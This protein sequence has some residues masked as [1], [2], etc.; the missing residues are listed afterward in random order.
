[1]LGCAET[2]QKIMVFM[3][4]NLFQFVHDFGV[5]K[6]ALGSHF[7]GFGVTWGTIF[8]IL[9]GPGEALK[10]QWILV[11]PLEHPKLRQ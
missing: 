9:Q 2:I 3:I 10:F 5:S 11:S 1:M 6:E 8:V 7:G 4:C